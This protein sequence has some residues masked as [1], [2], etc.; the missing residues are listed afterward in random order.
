MC[1]VNLQLFLRL[2]QTTNYLFCL[3]HSKH[4]A[5][6]EIILNY[7]HHRLNPFTALLTYLFT[8]LFTAHLQPTYSPLT[9]HLQFHLHLYLHLHLQLNIDL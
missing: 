5:L 2:I 4:S 8:A 1:E 7:Q 9:A 6:L 3:F